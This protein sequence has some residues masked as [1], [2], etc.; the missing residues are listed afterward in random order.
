M[1]RDVDWTIG[2]AEGVLCV[3]RLSQAPFEGTRY[4]IPNRK[5]DM[6]PTPPTL[7]GKKGQGA[8]PPP[9]PAPYTGSATRWEYLTE[10]VHL[11]DK[12][13]GKTKVSSATEIGSLAES[14]NRRGAEGWELVSVAPVIVVG[15]VMKSADRR[16]I[17][18]AIYK[19]PR[20]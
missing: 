10:G 5:T 16:E 20:S 6:T 19:R 14:M 4:R 15:K 12:F 9:P 17:T 7:P 3:V 8:T 18:V 13:L 11:G 1:V 2:Q